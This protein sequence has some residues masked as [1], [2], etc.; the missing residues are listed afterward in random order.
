VRH[1]RLPP[2]EFFRAVAGREP[3][4]QIGVA[5]WSSPLPHP[6]R[7]FDALVNGDRIGEIPNTNLSYADDPELNDRLADLRLR[8]LLAEEVA[9]A[10]AELDRLA[11]GRALIL[12][13]AVRS[14]RGVA[15]PRL[16]PACRASHG[17]FEVDLARL[18]TRKG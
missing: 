7:W 11:V 1:R 14:E 10:W 2:E 13:F 12:P 6:L 15:G 4:A 9:A 16:D 18:C 8:P 3:L 17:V 5:S